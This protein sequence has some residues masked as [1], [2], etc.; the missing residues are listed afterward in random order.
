[1]LNND[2]LLSSK[3]SRKDL[4][5]PSDYNSERSLPNAEIVVEK[6]FLVGFGALT[7]SE[8]ESVGCLSDMLR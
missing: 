7:C 1:M 4:K 8:Q 6:V 2:F 5:A 3:Y